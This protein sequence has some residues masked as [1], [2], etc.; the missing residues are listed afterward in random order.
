MKCFKKKLKGFGLA[1][2]VLAIGIFATI[3]SLLLLLV[4]DSTR[5]LENSRTRSKAALLVEEVNST[6]LML[7]SE[8][9]YSV[10]K[11]TGQGDFHFEFIDGEYVITSG[12]GDRNGL[13]YSFSIDLAQRDS[14]DIAVQSGGVVDP[15]TRLVLLD[16][17]WEDFIGRVHTINPV[18][19][20]ND[21]DTNSVV[22]TTLEDFQTG[23]HS[24]TM[25][26]DI[27]GG[28][29]RLQSMFYADWC[30][31]SLSMTA[32][33]LP[34]QAIATDISTHEGTVYMGTGGNASGIS[35]MKALVAGDPPVVTNEGIF[36]GYK[37]NDV[38]GVNGIA[39]L[40]TDNNA[41]EL[42]ILDV[43]SFPYTVTGY[44]D[45]TGPVDGTLIYYH[46]GMGFLGHG[47][48]L[49]I[50]DLSQFT[51]ARS[52]IRAMN[53]GSEVTDI[54][55]DDTYV[56]LTL[57]GATNDFVV[58]EYSPTFKLVGYGNL[59]SINATSLFVSE[60]SNRAYV[61]AASGA[62][63]EFFV[64]DMSTKTGSYPIISSYDTGLLSVNALTSVDD[65]AILVGIGGEEYTVLDITNESNPVRCGGLNIDTGVNALTLV[66]EGNNYYTYVVTRDSSAEFKIIRGGPGGGGADGNG[67]LP[68]GTYI[69]PIFDSESIT[70]EYYI[71]ALTASIPTGSTLQIQLRTSSDSNMTGTSWIGPDGTPST[72]YQTS[73]IFELPLNFTGRYLQ[74]K[75]VFESDTV[76]TPLIEEIVIN[77]EK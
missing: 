28:E 48:G 47:S 39:L 42:I 49:S 59:G 11:Y 75:A 72:F 10:A 76:V 9:W 4:V 15:H 35:F 71:L 27:N 5:T 41:Q 37:V 12:V 13:T 7:K 56:Y 50:I 53:L 18:I 74:Y 77:Y 43:S 66:K 58:Y 38:F 61:G 55:V 32:H 65:R 63:P 69:S 2:L 44:F 16:I 17:E 68:S 57:S 24:G 22:Y 52:V 20:I 67:Y 8:S 3:S 23:E 34:G 62:G 45:Y 21:W 30:N 70:S 6:L 60:D 14:N 36:D 25:A 33:D 19:Y 46:N 40:A 54:F 73:G 1:E 29:V 51:G 31:P 26:A 64:L